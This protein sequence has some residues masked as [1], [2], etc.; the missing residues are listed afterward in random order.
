MAISFNEIPPNLRVPLCY[1]EFD[2]SNAVQGLAEAEYQLLVLGQMLPTGS[3]D[4]AVPVR[5]LSADHAVALFGRGSML[6][7]MFDAIKGA[8]KWM[9]T[10]AI[11][12]ADADA[13]AAATGSITLT[14]TATAAGVLNCYVAGQR[15][16]AAV[17]AS[18]TAAEA[19]TAL[20]EA[21]NE[22]TDLPVTATA[23]DAVVTL[24]ARHKGECGNDID[25]RFN[26]YT[27][28]ALP[29]GL[30]VAVTAMAGGAG[31]PEVA[32]AIDVMGDE[33]WN[34]MAVPW[35]DGAN[36]AALEAELLTR[37][38]PMS[39]QDSQ[40]YTALRGT[41]AE[42]STWSA[43]RNSHL[44]SC[45][46]TGPSPVPAYIWAAVYATVA[47]VAVSD[48]PARP[49]QTL[50]L[51]GILAPAK[52]AR[53]TK[54]ERNLLLYDGLSTYTVDK[55][56][57]VKIERGVTSY[58]TNSYG[59]ED[60]S[61]LDVTTPATLSYI[62]YATRVRITTKFPRH[63]LADDGTR[64]GPGQ[65]IV[66]PSIIRAELLALFT[67]LEEQGLVENFAQF[68]A[69]LIVERNANDRNRLDVLAPPDLVNQLIL[70]AEQIQ[71]IL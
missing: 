39:M 34:A 23:A 70:F 14:G 59:L 35:T 1:I 9:E 62:R 20:A 69:D 56:G 32:D 3:A 19:A 52:E 26:Y 58:Q 11:P 54:E 63:K 50:A 36:M 29:T 49:L 6:A 51:P 2:N 22:E 15:V 7:A 43:S 61:Y 38:G 24:T 27:G 45:M 12:L 4:A 53:W 57:T 42:V 48:D 60:V 17:A 5:V 10:W 46:P 13:G 16:R 28:E 68:K 67:Q 37:W 71:F 30:N 33:W 41:H 31:N 21:I 25:V 55:D 65:K 18:D 40:A 64:F 47:S 66:T 8:D 44:V